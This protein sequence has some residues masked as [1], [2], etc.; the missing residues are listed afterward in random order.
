VTLPR[1][2]FECRVW[3]IAIVRRSIFNKLNNWVL[4][5]YDFRVYLWPVLKNP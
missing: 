1:I 3:E 2:E 4:I 5:V